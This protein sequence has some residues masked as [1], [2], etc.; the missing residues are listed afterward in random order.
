M[1][2]V[3]VMARLLFVAL[4][5]M[6]SC[7]SVPDFPEIGDAYPVTSGPKEHF[8]ASYYGVDSWSR[9]GRYV[10]VLE[11]ELVDRLPEADEPAL[12]CLVDLED[13][14]RLIPVAQTH[15]WNFQEATMFHWLDWADDTFIYNDRREGRFVSVIKNWVTGEERII[16]YPVSAVSPDGR[17]A[18]SINYARLHHTRPDYG[19]PGGGQEPLLEDSWPESDG[20]WLVDLMSGKAELIVS[21]A[22]QKERMTQMQ[23]PDGLAYF[24]HTVFSRDGSRIFWL[25]RTVENL[26]QQGTYV[27]KWKTTSF[28]C[29]SDGTDVRRC[30]PD[31]WG[32]SHF[33]WRDD[34]TI[35]VTANV[36]AGKV[37]GHVMHTVGDEENRIHLAPGMMD[38]NSHCLFSP[39]GKFMSCDG[40]IN[41]D[42]YRQ[43]VF[44]RMED[45]CLMPVGNYY[46]PK[47][48][49]NIYTRCDLH[50][51]FRRDGKQIGFNSVHGGSRQVYLRNIKW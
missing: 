37:V 29:N 39:D 40:Y 14:N 10:A 8:F 27:G 18:V 4:P 36:Y 38:W 3:H 48:Y 6:V 51:R 23:D 46:V 13:G 43:W 5:F 16:P 35:V 20:L 12:L 31:G 42:G 33:N 2:T 50:A 30:Y 15:C 7:S 28:T 47:K 49:R 9:D 17:K 32:G 24:C 26:K 11:T 44:M 25:A 1:S 21:V 22:S 34:K 19:Y 45:Q 41:K